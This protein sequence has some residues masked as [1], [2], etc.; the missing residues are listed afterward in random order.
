MAALVHVE[1]VTALYKKII[2]TMCNAADV[3]EN[4][5][6]ARSFTKMI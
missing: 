5:F 4:I 2:S 3:T 1:P 6:P